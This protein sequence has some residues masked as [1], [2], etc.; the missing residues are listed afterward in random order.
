[1]NSELMELLPASHNRIVLVRSEFSVNH[2]SLRLV[3]NATRPAS[4]RFRSAVGFWVEGSGFMVWGL[5]LRV[6]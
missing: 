4:A 1:M 6:S 3:F 2:R 5:G